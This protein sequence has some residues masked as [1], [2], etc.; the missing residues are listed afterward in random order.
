[1]RYESSS[2]GH[3]LLLNVRRGG[4]ALENVQFVIGDLVKGSYINP[5]I[6]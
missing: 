3:I 6:L 4:R 2:C 5:E 1:M